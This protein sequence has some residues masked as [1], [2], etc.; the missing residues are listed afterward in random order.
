MALQGFYEGHNNYL[1]SHTDVLRLE[2]LRIQN[3]LT[4]QLLYLERPIQEPDQLTA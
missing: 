4:E 3:H 1:G 2:T